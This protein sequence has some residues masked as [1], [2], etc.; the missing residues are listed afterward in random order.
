MTVQDSIDRDGG[1]QS[2]MSSGTSEQGYQVKRQPWWS[3]SRALST[4]K[5]IEATP[6]AAATSPLR[7]PS[8][9]CMTAPGACD[10]GI[11]P[12]AVTVVRAACPGVVPVR[13]LPPQANATVP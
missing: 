12:C 4:T 7:N 5:A 11:L 6:V 8:G 9:M 13:P 2:S 1:K 10:P 3:S